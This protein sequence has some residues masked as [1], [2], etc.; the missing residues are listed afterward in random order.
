VSAEVKAMEAMEAIGRGS[1]GFS[2]NPQEA[3]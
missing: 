2:P 1:M 3:E